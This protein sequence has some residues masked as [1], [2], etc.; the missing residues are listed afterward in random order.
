MVQ[1]QESVLQ[2]KRKLE[3]LDLKDTL[4]SECKILAAEVRKL[5]IIAHN[6]QADVENMKSPSIKGL[7]LTIAG[8]KQEALDKEQEEARLAQQNYELAAAKLE[9]ISYKLD[10]RLA[11]LKSLDL[12]EENLRI[13]IGYPEDP[14]FDTL[15]QCADKLPAIQDQMTTLM[16]QLVTVSKLGA[17]RSGTASTA[18]LAGTDDRLIS[19]EHKAQDLMI[20]LK[21]EVK[22]LAENLIPFGMAIDI[23]DLEN[24]KDDY[25]TD[26]YTSALITARVDKVTIALRQL[27]FRLDAIK[28]VLISTTTEYQ[29]EYL[30]ALIK[31]AANL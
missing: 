14:S 5:K 6:E 25:L 28:P 20:L 18:S 1:L 26:L 19:A 9:S 2:V 23:G 29:K 11:E 17:F 12:C 15:T 8:K 10:D 7:L 30:K 31:A 3:L 21:S 13:L 16:T 4:E 27:G 24:I 22:D